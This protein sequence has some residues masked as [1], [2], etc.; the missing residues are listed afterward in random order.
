MASLN[1]IH[2]PSIRDWADGVSIIVPTFRRPDGLK[3][4][5]ESLTFQSSLTRPIEIIVSDNDPEGS[6]KDNVAKFA[7]GCDF[8]VIYV[9][10]P[11]AGVANARNAAIKAVRGRYVA[12]LDDDQYASEDWLS[13][14]MFVMEDH[15]AGL[16]FCPTFAQSD[17]DVS[18][19]P[20]FLDFFTRKLPAP[21]RGPVDEF[22]GCGNSLLDLRQCQLPDPPFSPD[23]NETGGED[24]LLFSGLKNQ[25]IEIV[26]TDTTHASENVD[27]NRMTS[28]Y[29]RLRSFAYGQGPSR[30][31]ASSGRFDLLGLIK[32]TVIGTAQFCVFSPAALV[33]KALGH[34]SYIPFMRKACEGAGKVLWYNRFRPKIYGATALKAQLKREK[35]A[36]NAE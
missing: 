16:A 10:A 35:Q 14:L 22:F 4:A 23:T 15:G 30:I 31:C 5:L 29:I 11:E 8:P 13:E 32:W 28:E 3:A 33:T 9:H 36:F 20:Q 19:K 26:W 21:H 18:F 17:K 2:M 1:R 6:A 7:R 25:G 34:K 12:F 24:D 27:D